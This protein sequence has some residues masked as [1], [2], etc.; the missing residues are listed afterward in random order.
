MAAAVMIA[1]GLYLA[2]WFPKFAL[3]ESIGAPIWKRLEPLGRN[4]L[5]VQSTFKAYVFGIIWG[6]LPCG[7]VY[8]ALVW[9]ATSGSATQG[10]LFMFAFGA[11]TLPSMITAGIVASWIVRL[12]R[13]RYLRQFAG[14]TLIALAIIS[15]IVPQRHGLGTGNHAEGHTSPPAYEAVK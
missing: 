2:G 12:S 1:I 13:L 6:W 5:P 7:L 3:I 10:G 8:S 4:L 15:V 9:T 14:L 11:G